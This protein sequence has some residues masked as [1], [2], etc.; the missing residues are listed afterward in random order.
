MKLQFRDVTFLLHSADYERWI[1]QWNV[2]RLKHDKGR[3]LLEGRCCF[4]DVF[5]IE[6]RGYESTCT[7]CPLR[8]FGVEGKHRV[9]GCV[10]LIESIIG[11]KGANSVASWGLIFYTSGMIVVGNKGLES[12][13]KIRNAIEKSIVDR[14]DEHG[15]IAIFKR[16]IESRNGAA[17]STEGTSQKQEGEE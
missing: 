1:E 15:E 12:V 13:Q 4:C 8:V 11:D 10:V 3:F 6:R 9:E 2:D 5:R 7:E 16:E 14:S 17:E